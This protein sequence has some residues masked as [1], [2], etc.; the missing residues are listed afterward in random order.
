MPDFFSNK[1]QCFAAAQRLKE[2]ADHYGDG[3]YDRLVLLE[4]ASEFEKR[5]PLVEQL[6]NPMQFQPC[7]SPCI[8]SIKPYQQESHERVVPVSLNTE[9]LAKEIARYLKE[10]AYWREKGGSKDE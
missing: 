9:E 1:M 8:S 7:V 4:A 2:I 3:S 6:L 10:S 5:A